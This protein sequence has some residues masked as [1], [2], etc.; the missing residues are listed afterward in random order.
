MKKRTNFVVMT[1]WYELIE[2]LTDEQR[3]RVL[4]IMFK[5]ALGEKYDL[6]SEEIPVRIAMRYIAASM[7]RMNDEYDE[8][9]KK[10]A[11]NGRKGGRP[12]TETEKSE[13]FSEKPKKANGFF[14]NPTE[15]E[16][17][18]GLE[19]KETRKK[20]E[21]SQSRDD[22]PYQ[23]GKPDDLH[24]D[25][26][27][28]AIKAI[29]HLNGRTGADYEPTTPATLK[30]VSARLNEGATLDDFKT[31]IDNKTSDWLHDSDMRKYL[32]PQTLF[33][34]KF[35]SYLQER[36]RAAPDPAYGEPF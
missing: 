9:C 26:R 31:V 6:E 5:V 11:E 33:G 2:D 22:G 4:D 21:R 34:P 30:K 17:E 15:T 25:T 19:K 36:K 14:E 13:R 23:S 16:T 10:N 24:P 20:K 7:E 3:G 28:T 35:E 32:R 18:T 27:A 29:E 8:K 1:D 12:R